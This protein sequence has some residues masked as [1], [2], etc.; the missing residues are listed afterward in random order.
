M[1]R[2]GADIA[3]VFLL[4]LSLALVVF[5]LLV[6]KGH[7]IQKSGQPASPAASTAARRPPPP[8]PAKVAPKPTPAA[9]TTAT[10]PVRIT[11]TASRGDCW[12]EAHRRS[13]NGKLLARLLLKEG[14]R[15]TLYG[16]HIWLGLGAAGHVDISVNG[17]VRP[18]RS[19]T[20]SILLG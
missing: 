9:T 13:S 17:R 8:P 16:P 4:A 10:R 2:R 11:I 3:F 19:G 7:F 15:I 5:G 14:R 12:V 6:W 18:V 1:R 20:T